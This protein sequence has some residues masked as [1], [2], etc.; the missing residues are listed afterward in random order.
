[1]MHTLDL[2]TFFIPSYFTHALNVVYCCI[3][4]LAGLRR[5]QIKYLVSA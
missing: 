2:Y 4:E 3:Q 1:M 5:R